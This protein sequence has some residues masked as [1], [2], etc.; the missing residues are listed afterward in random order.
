MLTRSFQGNDPT[1]HDYVPAEG[2]DYQD[3]MK[4]TYRLRMIHHIYKGGKQ[5]QRNNAGDHGVP[6]IST[7]GGVFPK[8]P[9]DDEKGGDERTEYNE[10]AKNMYSRNVLCKESI[11]HQPRSHKHKEDGTGCQPPPAD[12]W[13]HPLIEADGKSDEQKTEYDKIG[14]LNPAVRS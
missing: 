1:T 14:I 13:T 4:E 11:I 6:A 5:S 2:L 7:P 10:E 3:A 12:H 9:P 8:L